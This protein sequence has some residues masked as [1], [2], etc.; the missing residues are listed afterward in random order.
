MFKNKGFTLIELAIVLIILGIL[1]GVGAGM[2]GISIKTNQFDKSRRI[3][4][5][6]KEA[7]IGFSVKNMR[8]PTKTEFSNIAKDTDAWG[9]TLVYIPDDANITGSANID[10]TGD[11]NICC[12]N[13][14]TD[15]AVN[16]RRQGTDN[17]KKDIAFVIL[18]TGENRV[19]DTANATH[20]IDGNSY[21]TMIVE[22]IGPSYD[23]IVEYA[24]LNQLVS[25]AGS[26]PLYRVKNS[27]GN[28]L[29]VRGGDYSSCTKIDKNKNNTFV[30]RSGQT[31][32]MINI[33]TKEKDCKDNKNAITTN[34]L[35]S[36]N[37]LRNKDTD[38]DC[39]I[40]ITKEAGVYFLQD[41]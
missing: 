13:A 8:L 19:Q 14:T 34:P 2:L 5:E 6:A 27:T 7:I 40:K 35:F 24:S 3:V 41:E 39:Y 1:V 21:F 32:K 10:L 18:S 28:D 30:V 25:S 26:Y 37:N 9:R 23:D 29:W 38:R 15:L 11:I 17:Y 16:D 12:G 20:T 4:E 36:F 22:E 31:E 33:Y